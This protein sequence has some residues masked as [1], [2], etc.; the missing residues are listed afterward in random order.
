MTVLAPRE[1]YRRWA[2]TYERETAVT[3]LED[4]LVA[5]MTPSLP[6]K[7][8]L[9]VGCGTGRR[10][11]GA[12]AAEAVGVEP[13]A[14]MIATGARQG[15]WSPEISVMEGDVLALPVASGSF[16]VV[17]CRLVLGHV[18]ELDRAYAELARVTT[19]GGLL[20]VTDFHA[21][22]HAAGHR[23]TFR[24]AEGIHE[25]EHHV[26]DLHAHCAAALAAGLV[27]AEMRTGTV[28]PE[29]RSFYEAALRRAA[30]E[31][32]LGL[33]LVLALDFRKHV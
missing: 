10:L 26:H 17:W 28:G 23:R 6:G 19:S 4:S 3:A 29:I 12:G 20:I 15:P 30:Y 33:P 8:L 7:R 11:R 2:P 32:D 25:I 13:C 1:A 16:D 24:D 22:A 18:A 9:D 27:P 31:A 5:E 21:D 14:E